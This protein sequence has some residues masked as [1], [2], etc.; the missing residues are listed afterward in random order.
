MTPGKAQELLRTFTGVPLICELA[1][2]YIDAA[3]RVERVRKLI[4]ASDDG[5]KHEHNGH[6]AHEGEAECP[7]CWAADILR[8]LDG[9]A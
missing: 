9:D 7:G 8:A 2:A 4:Y 3:A 5:T 6:A 1:Q